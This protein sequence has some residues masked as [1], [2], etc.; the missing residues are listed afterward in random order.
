MLLAHD[1]PLGPRGALTRG[2]PGAAQKRLAELRAG[3]L[4]GERPEPLFSLLSRAR[5]AAAD[6]LVARSVGAGAPGA[7]GAAPARPARASVPFADPAGHG[8]SALLGGEAAPRPTPA[9][10]GPGPTGTA[11]TSRVG[12]LL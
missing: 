1:L 4:Q 8:A 3:H 2:L 7:T 11:P 5:L 10:S 12:P 9:A 6:A